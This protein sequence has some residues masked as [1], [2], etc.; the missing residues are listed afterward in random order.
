[1]VPCDVPCSTCLRRGTAQGQRL[2]KD[3]E[4]RHA[5]MVVETLDCMLLHA[6][7]NSR[8]ASRGDESQLARVSRRAWFE[9]RLDQRIQR[10]RTRG[11]SPGPS[12]SLGSAAV[13]SRAAAGRSPAPVITDLGSPSASK[14]F[15]PPG[16]R[17]Q[18]VLPGSKTSGSRPNTP[19]SPLS[20][21]NRPTL[22]ALMKSEPPADPGRESKVCWVGIFPIRNLNMGPASSAPL[23][24]TRVPNVS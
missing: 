10:P 11:D 24:R 20:G 1:M 5:Q 16:G 14:G 13:R 8:A 23:A 9:L 12:R 4:A 15:D 19:G 6:V 3:L 2:F 21:K 7:S 18:P 17:G 22:P